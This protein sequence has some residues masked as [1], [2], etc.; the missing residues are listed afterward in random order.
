MIGLEAH[1]G[2]ACLVRMT[3]IG[4]VDFDSRVWHEKVNEPWMAKTL[5]TRPFEN[6]RRLFMRS[7]HPFHYS[8]THFT[9]TYICIMSYI[10]VQ[11]NDSTDMHCRYS[12]TSSPGHQ[13]ARSY[14]ITS[15]FIDFSPRL[16]FSSSILVAR[17]VVSSTSGV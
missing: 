2:F 1:C 6:P 5:V 14:Q 7:D 15:N 9:N 13:M 16:S 8:C 4:G 11:E 3:C 17:D 12:S 10:S